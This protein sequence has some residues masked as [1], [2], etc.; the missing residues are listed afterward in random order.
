MGEMESLIELK[1]ISVSFPGRGRVL[2]RLNFRLFPGERVGIVGANGS[3]K[4]TLLHIIMGLLKPDSGIIRIFGRER[5]EEKDFEDI[6][7]KIGLLFQDS[8]NQLFSPTVEEDI[9]FGPLNQRKSRGEVVRIVEDMLN[10]FGLSELRHRFS[11][12]LSFGEK[13]LVALAT[14][15]AMEPEIL[16]LDEPT[17]ALDKET[18]LRVIEFLNN[19]PS[20]TLCVVSHDYEFL[21]KVT[22]KIYSLEKGKLYPVE[23]TGFEPATSTVRR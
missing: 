10:I 4:S 21:R 22:R 1:D 23:Q 19:S 20:F 5:R 12:T 14:V 17:T 9:A 7:G 3:G 11:H 2:D 18:S 6:R 15:L 16:L 13:K 8:D